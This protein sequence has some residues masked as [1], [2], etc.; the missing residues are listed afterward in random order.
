MTEL[1]NLLEIALKASALAEEVILKYYG[2]APEI[3]LKEDHTPVTIADQKAEE[4]MRSFLE[5]ETPSC[6]FVGEEFG[7]ENE[8]AKY[9]WIMDPIDGT[10]SFVHEVPLF[11]T[12]LALFIDGKPAVGL[13]RLPALKT[14]LWASV[15]GGAFVDGRS[16]RCS[17]K[18]QLNES[19]VLSGTLNTM[20]DRGL[21]ES[22]KTLR[23]RSL[24][25]RGWGDCYGYYLV[26][27]GRAEVMVD[28]VVSLWDIAPLPVIF[29][30]A[31]G[32]FSTISG[33]REL[34]GP[35]AKPLHSIAEGYT[36]L[37]TA[38]QV[39][40]ETQKIFF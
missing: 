2:N 15:G 38:P 31:G 17:S 33:E 3:S 10:K 6:G 14:C 8:S 1:N 29:S 25:H 20:E 28:P 30:E 9:Q 32:V 13:I 12:L 21:G 34:F 26:A 23:R 24:L 7:I 16:A 19:L 11:G 36:G 4:V 5:R 35:D 18:T 40:T 39:Y 22:F 27:T 37:A